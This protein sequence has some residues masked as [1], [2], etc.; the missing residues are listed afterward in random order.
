MGCER[1]W[2]GVVLAGL[3]PKFNWATWRLAA[4]HGDNMLVGN[5]RMYKEY[6]RRWRAVKD[7]RDA[8]V[9]F[10]QAEAWYDQYSIDH[11]PRLLGKWLEYLHALNLEQF[12]SDVWKAVLKANQHSPEL[13]PEAIRRDGAVEYCY[14][15]MKEMFLVDEGVSPPYFVTGNKMR[16]E[17]VADLLNFLFL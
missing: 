12:D 13:T 8:Y 6:K 14:R 11:N 16:F 5:L 17:R 15:D 9:R 2:I 4:P 7:L 10:N 3:C 1:L